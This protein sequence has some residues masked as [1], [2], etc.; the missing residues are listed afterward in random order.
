[1]PYETVRDGN[2]PGTGLPLFK[3]YDADEYQDVTVRYPRPV[4][5]VWGVGV[6]GVTGR[7]V[8]TGVRWQLSGSWE[9]SP[10]YPVAAY[11]T[12]ARAMIAAHEGA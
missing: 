6:R 10:L 8:P 2:H 4:G 7:C 9:E 3:V 11:G 1:M 5:E 12:A